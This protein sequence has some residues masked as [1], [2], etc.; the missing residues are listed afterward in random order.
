VNQNAYISTIIAALAVASGR[1][2]GIARVTIGAQNAIRPALHM[3]V[4]M[5]VRP[6]ND[7]VAFGAGGATRA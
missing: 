6:R 5:W 3:K 2:S 4:K 1:T 7:S